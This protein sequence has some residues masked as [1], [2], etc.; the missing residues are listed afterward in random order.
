MILG[1]F[2]P[3]FSTKD[4]QKIIKLK[5]KSLKTMDVSGTRYTRMSR[6]KSGSKVR[7]S[8]L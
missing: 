4:L 1:E 7:I 5:A 3:V 6:W 2:H 8:G